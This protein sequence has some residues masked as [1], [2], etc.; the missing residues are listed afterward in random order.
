MFNYMKSLFKPKSIQAETTKGFPPCP[1][2]IGDMVNI[3]LLE[4]NTKKFKVYYIF[5]K[6]NGVVV[7]YFYK[8]NTHKFCKNV[9]DF[10]FSDDS[11]GTIDITKSDMMILS[12]FGDF[13]SEWNTNDSKHI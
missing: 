10:E 5:E 9:D 1:F 8:G 13:Y 3:K 12:L 2:K 6:S 11:I 7:E 4:D